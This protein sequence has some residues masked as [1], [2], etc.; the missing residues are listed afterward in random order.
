[1][2]AELV[3][4]GWGQRDSGLHTRAVRGDRPQQLRYRRVCAVLR[5][6]APGAQ[7]AASIAAIARHVDC[8]KPPR[9][10]AEQ[11]YAWSGSGSWLASPVPFRSI[12]RATDASPT[13]A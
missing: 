8:R 5:H 2:S 4:Q 6:Q 10:L 3:L 1:M 11:D 13:M 7:S 12:A 9:Y